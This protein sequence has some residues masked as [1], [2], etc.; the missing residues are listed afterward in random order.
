MRFALL[1][2]LL[3]ALAWPAHATPAGDPADPKTPV[4]ALQ[5]RSV[6]ARPAALV[7]DPAE[8]GRW[9]AAH[10]AVHRAGG[11]RAYAREPVPPA[12]AASAAKPNLH[13]HGAPQ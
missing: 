10:E 8:P 12:P 6:L 4:P 1:T 9:R 2:P 7:A 3:A 11:W 5:H 13:H